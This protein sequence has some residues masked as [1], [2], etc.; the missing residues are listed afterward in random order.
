MYTPNEDSIINLEN[1]SAIVNGKGSKQRE[2]YFTTECKV[3][4]KRYLESREDSSKALF[5]TESHPIRR[6]S[7]PTI[8][9]SLKLLAARGEV[10]ANVY[11]HRF[12]QYVECLYM[13]NVT[14]E[15]R[16]KA[17]LP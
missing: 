6:L 5:V 3:W 8:R 10:A 15:R 17:I 4:L 13:G 7:I 1:C 2:V 14:K 12:R 16:C 9:H 11:P